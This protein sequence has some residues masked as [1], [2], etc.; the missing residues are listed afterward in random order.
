MPSSSAA[1][2]A[3]G[4]NA[5]CRPEAATAVGRIVLLELFQGGEQLAQIGLK[6]L[7]RARLQLEDRR[8]AVAELRAAQFGLELAL[9]GEGRARD[10]AHHGELVGQHGQGGRR[11]PDEADE[12]DGGHRGHED[13]ERHR[14]ALRAGTS[15]A[16]DVRTVLRRFRSGGRRSSRSSGERP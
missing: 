6:L 10:D 7:Q 2:R 12:H 3:E 9:V 8:H 11:H 1:R 16:T 15:A 13:Q 4:E 14:L 5:P